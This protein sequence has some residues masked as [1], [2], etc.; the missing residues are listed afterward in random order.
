MNE[1]SMQEY[2]DRLS[3]MSLEELR[4]EAQLWSPKDKV[5]K[6]LILKHLVSNFKQEI[7]M[8]T[9]KIDDQKIQSQMIRDLKGRYLYI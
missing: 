5:I 7:S 9:I 6:R 8:R 4:M 3:E 1:Q 2:T